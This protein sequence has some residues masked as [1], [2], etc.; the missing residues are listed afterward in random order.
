MKMLIGAL[1]LALALA[2]PAFAQAAPA[3]EAKQHCC[4][5]MKEEGK[6]CCCKDM[7]RM[8]HDMKGHGKQ[9]DGARGG[10]DDH[11]GHAH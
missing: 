3:P 8:D 1:A 10:H 7:A 5:K 9:G 4:E 6:Q 2:V 11:A